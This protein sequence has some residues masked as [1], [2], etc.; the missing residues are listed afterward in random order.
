MIV[1]PGF[2]FLLAPRNWTFEAYRQMLSHPSFLRAAYLSE[3]G[4]A[5]S[6]HQ[7]RPRAPA[8][9]RNRAKLVQSSG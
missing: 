6:F 8:V 1:S 5:E 2:G 7:R 3:D 9:G 4:R